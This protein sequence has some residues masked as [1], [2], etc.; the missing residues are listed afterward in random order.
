MIFCLFIYLFFLV[1]YLIEM[2]D[3]L[4]VFFVTLAGEHVDQ[5]FDVN[6]ALVVDVEVVERFVDLFCREFF[7]PGRQRV[8]QSENLKDKKRFNY[9]IETTADVA[10]NLDFNS[11]EKVF[12]FQRLIK[13][14]SESK[15]CKNLG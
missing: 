4:I 8:F 11:T 7:A 14:N 6:E 12:Y 3:F 5:G 1:D 13:D 9:K 15:L 10:K 2:A